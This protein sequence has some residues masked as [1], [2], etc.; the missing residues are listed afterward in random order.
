MILRTEYWFLHLAACVSFVHSRPRCRVLSHYPQ[1]PGNITSHIPARL[2]YRVTHLRPSIVS[3]K[4]PR[5][6]GEV[7][8]G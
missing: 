7:D 6:G 1:A 8:I 4:F 3:Y 2:V 5:M